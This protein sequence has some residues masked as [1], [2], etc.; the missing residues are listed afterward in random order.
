MGASQGSPVPIES[1]G[2]ADRANTSSSQH[3]RGQ[4]PRPRA[5]EH[6]H[7]LNRTGSFD[8][9]RMEN[10]EVDLS[11]AE[12]ASL[13]VAMSQNS[14]RA[15]CYANEGALRACGMRCFGRPA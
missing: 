11:M 9:E 4:N 13:Y 8:G 12:N 15:G 6:A 14:N 1:P 3:F 7:A 10:Q 2:Q 5:S